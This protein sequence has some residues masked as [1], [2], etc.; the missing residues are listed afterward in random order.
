MRLKT[1]SNIDLQKW[2][3]IIRAAAN[4]GFQIDT[5]SGEITNM[6]VRLRWDWNEST[7]TLEIA[8]LESTLISQDQALSYLDT[9]VETA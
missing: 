6:G 7:S 1:Y 4:Y 3:A 2:L 9:I 8:I 5:R